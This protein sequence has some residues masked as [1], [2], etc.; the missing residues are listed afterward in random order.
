MTILRLLYVFSILSIFS[1][2]AFAERY[3]MNGNY[4]VRGSEKFGPDDDNKVGVLTKGSSF[5]VVSKQRYANGAEALEIRILSLPEKRNA[6]D[7]V[8][9]SKSGKY[10]IYK[11]NNKDFIQMNDATS[12]EANTAADHCDSCA[13]LVQQ[14]PPA[15]ARNTGDIAAI[16]TTIAGQQ[17][18]APMEEKKPGSLDEQIK[19]YSE[20]DEV[21][22]TI[23]YAMK[24]KKPSS[25]GSC[26]R[27]V[28]K[29]MLASPKGKKGL[30]PQYYS[31]GAAL[32][33]KTA[34]K[35]FGFVNLLDSEPYK[36]QMKSPSNAPKGAVLVYSSGIPCTDKAG[37]F[38]PDCG[39][40]EIKT[41]DSGK[42]GYVSDY[43]SAAAINETAGA[44]KYT[45]R[46][47]LVGVMIKP[48][49]D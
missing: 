30:I 39:H 32:G 13:K 27:G 14:A 15:N 20:S 46:Y 34:L 41:A 35:K 37:T 28:K 7:E 24:N 49:K 43:Y 33:A 36:S 45:T 26:Y 3:R 8:K 16:S 21:N 40:T 38:H 29:A 2:H 11:P 4:Y 19:K 18:Q 42:P 1:A 9:Q 5:E 25:V 6:G 22:Y 47:K 17:N 44:R 12:T 10:F 31:D 23:N 48:A